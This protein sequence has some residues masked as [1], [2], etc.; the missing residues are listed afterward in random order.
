MTLLQKQHLISLYTSTEY[1][2]RPK[3]RMVGSVNVCWSTREFNWGTIRSVRVR[4]HKVSQD[5]KLIPFND[6]ND[7]QYYWLVKLINKN[8]NYPTPSM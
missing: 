1:I 7:I 5:T 6:V 4:G 8:R 2:R 3:E